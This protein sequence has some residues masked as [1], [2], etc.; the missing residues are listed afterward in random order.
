MMRLEIVT[1]EVLRQL[2]NGEIL[3]KRT[4]NVQFTESHFFKKNGIEVLILKHQ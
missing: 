1:Q 2:K 3:I 4:E